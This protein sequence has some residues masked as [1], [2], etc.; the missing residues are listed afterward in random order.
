MSRGGQKRG[1]QW[2]WNMENRFGRYVDHGFSA[3][4]GS[5]PL[6]RVKRT[7]L[8]NSFDKYQAAKAEDVKIDGRL[9]R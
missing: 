9:Q 3:S 2:R 6:G 7:V 5:T 8:G 1:L 4:N